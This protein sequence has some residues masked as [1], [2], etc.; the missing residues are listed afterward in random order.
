MV[1]IAASRL[2]LSVTA[3][4]QFPFCIEDRPFYESF[5]CCQLSAFSLRSTTFGPSRETLYFCVIVRG[6]AVVCLFFAHSV[7]LPLST[8]VGHLNG[9]HDLFLDC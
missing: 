6:F 7:L 1:V 2:Q 8:H 9:S 5:G 4:R 3:R